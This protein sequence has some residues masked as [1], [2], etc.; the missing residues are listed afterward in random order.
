MIGKNVINLDYNDFIRGM[1]T[2]DNVPDGGFSNLT[3]NVNLTYNPGV[4]YQP[5]ASTD[6]STNL[7]DNIIA[8]CDDPSYLGNDK[9]FLDDT[10]AFYIWNG[11]SLTKKVTASSD[12]F[13]QGTTDFTAW[14]NTANGTM[15]YATTKAG[16][17]GDIVRWD[18][19]TTLVETFWS[20]ASYLNQAALSASTAYRPLLV[21]EANLYI[22]DANKLHRVDTGLTVSNGIVTFGANEVITALSIDKGSGYMLIATTFGSDYSATKNGSS[23]LYLYDGYSNKP[24]KM[25][26][27]NGVVTAFKN[28]DDATYI[29]Y[30]NKLGVF[31]GNGIKFLRT[32][33]FSLGDSDKLV[34]PHR[35]TS[36]ENTLYWAENNK[37]IAYGEVRGGAGKVFYPAFKNQSTSNAYKTITHIGA[38]KLGLAYASSQF[39]TFDTT[40][41]S[42]PNTASIYFNRVNFQRPVY[43]RE[44]YVE[45]QDSISNNIDMGSLFII[46]DNQSTYTIDLLNNTGST[47]YSIRKKIP[48]NGEKFN[49]VQPRLNLDTVNK[50]IKRI[51]ISYDVAE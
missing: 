44:M 9:M 19:N 32:L 13:T 18:G 24:A 11:T 26:P 50:G 3:D 27:I 35:T 30:G 16:A 25:I 39:F 28:L 15:Y 46:G 33:G 20:G 47:V 49:S 22:G 5:A 4:I 12:K 43:L 41:V 2:S 48:F 10:G 6:K 38:G 40:S 34:Y 29:F 23:R 37:V 8:A 7:T 36:I 45:F 17:S 1:S 14:Y 51:V 21:Y 42:T 31:T